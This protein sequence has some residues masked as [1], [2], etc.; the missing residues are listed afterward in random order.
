MGQTVSQRSPILIFKW[1]NMLLVCLYSSVRALRVHVH[2]RQVIFFTFYK[3]F[4]LKKKT[5]QTTLFCGYFSTTCLAIKHNSDNKKH[6]RH[7]SSNLSNL[8]KIVKNNSK[9]FPR[10][11][12]SHEWYCL[13]PGSL[14]YQYCHNFPHKST[15]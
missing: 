6:L 11:Y 4:R 13:L 2:I 1:L 15:R 10:V 7:L 8:D 14:T 5:N 9:V 12:F 3:I